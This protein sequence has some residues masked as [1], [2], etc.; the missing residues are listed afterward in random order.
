MDISSNDPLTVRDRTM[1]EVMYGAGLRLSELVGLNTGDFDLATGEVR[2]LGKG[3]K[4]RKV[5]LGKTAVAC[6]ERW[7]PLRELYDRRP[8][9][10]YLHQ[11][12]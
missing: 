6:L 9:G 3:S 1:L 5:P 12:R 4:E 10:V 7:L 11:K 8:G 2:V